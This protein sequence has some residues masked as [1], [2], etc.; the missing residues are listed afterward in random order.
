MRVV[1]RR[2]RGDR[3]KASRKEEKTHCFT[4]QIAPVSAD[5]KVAAVSAGKEIATAAKATGSVVSAAASTV[6]KAVVS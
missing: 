5:L 2:G 6:K 1:R 4:L 3:E